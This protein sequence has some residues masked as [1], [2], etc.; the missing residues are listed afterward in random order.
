MRYV[1]SVKWVTVF[2]L[3]FL[4]SQM[5]GQQSAQ[6]ASG[7]LSITSYTFVSQVPMTS[8]G[9]WKLTYKATILNTG[10]ALAS[11]TA[12]VQSLNPTVE[13]TVAGQTTLTFGQIPT[14]GQVLSSNTFQLVIDRTK[15]AN[16][17]TD[18]LWTF[19]STP[20]APVANAGQN[21]SVLVNALVQL[22]GSGSTNPSGIGTLTYS[23]SI[24]QKPNGSL[25]SVQPSNALMPT[26][27]VDLPGSYLINLT[28]S[29]GVASS[30]ATVTITTGNS[31][32]V[33]N[34]GPGQ[35][36]SVGSPVVL[37]GIGSYDVDGD[38]ITYAWTMTMQPAGSTASLTGA[39]TVSPTF[40]ADK[41]GSYQIE[42]IV[43]DGTFNSA[44]SFVTISTSNTPPTANPGPSQ[45]VNVGALVQLDGSHSFDVDGDSL[46][47]QWLIL[48]KPLNSTATLSNPTAVNPTFTADLPGNYAVQ[49]TVNDGTFNS[50]PLNVTIGTN[51][52]LP[53]TANAGP[54]QSVIDNA[55]VTLSGSGFDPNGLTLTYQWFL[56]SKPLNSNAVLTN[57]TTQNP[58]FV[59]DKAGNYTAQLTVSDGY[60]SS[61][62]VTVMI[63]SSNV[64]PTANAGSPQTVTVGTTVTLDGSGSTDPDHDPLT[65]L[66]SVNS[67]P[68]GS[69]VQ[70]L[71]Q[72]TAQRPTFVPDVAGT[73]V[74]QLIVND[75]YVN[76][77]PP[78]TVTITAT[79]QM[80][81]TLTPNP[82]TIGSNALGTLSVMLSAPAGSSGQTVTLGSGTPNV[83]NVPSSV[84]VPANSMGANATVTPGNAIGSTLITASAGGFVSGTATVNVV[85]PTI[86]LALASGTIG[87]TSTVNGTITLNAPAPA[88]GTSVALSS[89]PTGI[90]DVEPSSVMIAG[91]NTTG[92][93]TVTGLATGTTT[94]S[95]ASSGYVS[96]SVNGTVCGAVGNCNRRRRSEYS[97]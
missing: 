70:T 85:T 87:L 88:G 38:T 14:G 94:V 77:Y 80:T 75:G 20:L 91:G 2:I 27:T 55:T 1:C 13:T 74:F 71:A 5:Y 32:P 21:Q 7:T 4:S 86:T 93:F 42:L 3:L 8:T 78:A 69:A 81:I 49:L 11:A 43:N 35:T 12:T 54:P 30:S 6:S 18:L 95:G 50:P 82:L 97:S 33:A 96:G 53:P 79:A 64:A 25:A 67:W 10:A 60:V 19:T 40:T 41:Y 59:A 84:F 23:W 9:I 39:N 44:P 66:W 48:S 52:P 51:P 28:V 34:A 24:T 57:P 45:T 16:F 68:Q 22:D 92:A 73:Y 83:A 76:S 37:T 46:T 36:V 58:T 72:A 90:L 56:I 61:I 63:S 26:F 65:Y 62:P 29:N 17:N 31:P 15:T 89:L 47:Y